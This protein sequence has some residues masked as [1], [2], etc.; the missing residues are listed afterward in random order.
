MPAVRQLVWQMR[1]RGEV[2][3]L[4]KGAVLP[5]DTAIDEVRGPIRVR[6]IWKLPSVSKYPLGL[7]Q[8]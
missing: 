8:P 7:K 6:K 2:E 4:Q 5:P 3:I 1:D